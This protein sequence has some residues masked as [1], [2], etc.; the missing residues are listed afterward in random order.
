MK[1]RSHK[2]KKPVSPMD[3]LRRELREKT[4]E[5][6]L[7]RRI[8]ESISSN[9]DLDSVLKE[10]VGIVVQVTRAD[11]CLLYLHDKRNRELV[12]KAS[13]NP[14]G[15]LIGRIR[16]E[17]G[18]GITGWAAR[19]R[20]V[21]TIPRH[22]SD[23]PRFKLFQNLPEDRFEALLSIP[24]IVRNE[25]IGVINVQHKRPHDTSESDRALLATIGQQAG[26]AIENAQ[27]YAE[28]QR[29]AVQIETLSAVSRTISS[30]R[31]IEEILHLIVTLTAEMMSS[32]ICSV[33][34]LNEDRQELEIVATQSLSGAYREKAN[35]KIGHSISGKAVLEKRPISILNVARENGYV[36]R[37]L[38]ARE[39][40]TSML[41][42]P[43]IIRDRAIGV[44]NIYTA[45]EHKF[46]D[47]E[48]KILQAVAN[49]SA[50]SL[51]NTR[52][53]QRSMAAEG[54]LETRKVV[55][56]AKGILMKERK[57]TEAEA[58]KV[59]Q[60]QSMNSRKSMREVAE[61]VL[62]THGMQEP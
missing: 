23:D 20:R 54:E 52:L 55:E 3:R 51:E 34:L 29:K 30:S 41:S 27:L 14:N 31:Y 40:L 53:L 45:Q 13:N 19:E 48:V 22:A 26:G 62:L 47:D 37:D 28:M 16:L 60:R 18:E 1:K 7:L 9:L 39:G 2:T 61:A 33:M 57:I 32:K 15:R 24:L 44:I 12:L 43:M 46:T 10:I 11:A 5:V 36:Y 58:F 17:L 49:Q 21:V 50:V 6:G 42:V 35:V 38:A 56:R 25:V 59:I 8:S 4:R